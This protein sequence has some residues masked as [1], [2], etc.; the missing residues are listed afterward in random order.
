MDLRDDEEGWMIRLVNRDKWF[1]L[2]EVVLKLE[3]LNKL[4]TQA[5]YA[6]LARERRNARAKIIS[7]ARE[8][9]ARRA[10]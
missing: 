6:G 8:L 7:T 4:P 5:S 1:R 2:R 3:R 9:F 10:G